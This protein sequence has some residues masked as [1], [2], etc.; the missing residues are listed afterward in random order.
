[1]KMDALNRKTGRPPKNVSQLGSRFLGVRSTE[2]LS[3]ETDDS[4]RQIQR[5]IRLNKLIPS[6]QKA[7]EDKK[8][9]FNPA[10]EISYL[11]PADQ[12]VVQ[13]VMSREETAPSLSQ[14]QKL[15]KM[16]N[17]GTIN[18]EK[19]VE[20]LTVQKPMYETITFRFNTVEEYF[21]EGTTGKQMQ[22]IIMGLLRDYQ[23]RWHKE[24]EQKQAREQ[25]R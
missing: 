6:L 20:V 16:A 7:V 15:K 3:K 17:D 9:A 13:E 8:L 22:E 11:N 25:E 24:R 10:V 5:Y 19:I 21:P 2:L 14:A 4:P 1:M 18:D 12:A 23:E